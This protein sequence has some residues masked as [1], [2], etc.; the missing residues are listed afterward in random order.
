VNHVVCVVR[1]ESPVACHYQVGVTMPELV[2]DDRGFVSVPQ[3]LNSVTMSPVVE[4]QVRK[5]QLLNGARMNAQALAFSD[6]LEDQRIRGE[7][8]GVL[9]ENLPRPQLS[10]AYN[11]IAPRCF[12][13]LRVERSFIE[14]DV[15]SADSLNDL[16]L[17][18]RS[19]HQS[20]D[21]AVGHR[22]GV[23]EC[24][25]LSTLK[26]DDFSVRFRV[27][28]NITDGVVRNDFSLDK[29][30][31]KDGKRSAVSVPG[32]VAHGQSGKELGDSL[33]GEVR[34]RKGVS[35]KSADLPLVLRVPAP[36]NEKRNKIG[37][38]QSGKEAVKVVP[39]VG[40]EDLGERNLPLHNQFQ[41][42][43]VVLP[44]K[45]V[46]HS[47]HSLRGGEVIGSQSCDDLASIG[48]RDA[49]FPVIPAFGLERHA[50]AKVGENLASCNPASNPNGFP[51][52]LESGVS[53][54]PGR[55]SNSYADLTAGDFETAYAPLVKLAVPS[56]EGSQKRTNPA[57][58]GHSKVT[59]TV[60]RS[61]SPVYLGDNPI[62][63]GFYLGNTE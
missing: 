47:L 37:F 8:T 44:R 16:P 22:Q 20:L 46:P 50:G 15:S 4:G 39:L 9:I 3:C 1:D 29:P 54:Y 33:P 32:G 59:L 17:N 18:A 58:K 56:I 41:R 61:E 53:L 45:S 5:P 24:L 48:K 13:A 36:L 60:T 26:P 42:S 25:G 40:V 12:P 63:G 28:G 49:G 11:P 19:G 7:V 2:R 34:G 52:M 21:S 23:D 31:G 35:E 30:R 38:G 27:S 6:T 51:M 55:D 57:T 43:P 14:V 10:T 62:S